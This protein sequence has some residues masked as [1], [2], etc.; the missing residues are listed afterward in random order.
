MGTKVIDW[1]LANMPGFT[2]WVGGMTELGVVVLAFVFLAV[3]VITYNAIRFRLSGAFSDY[4]PYEDWMDAE[5]V[6]V[7]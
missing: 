6:E 1:F 5:C 4:E 7:M 2:A 3:V